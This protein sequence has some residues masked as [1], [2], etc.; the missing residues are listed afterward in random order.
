VAL[1]RITGYWS[2]VTDHVLLKERGFFNPALKILFK[3]KSIIDD[4]SGKGKE[5]VTSNQ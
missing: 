5:K 1:Y 3:N 2:L 4:E